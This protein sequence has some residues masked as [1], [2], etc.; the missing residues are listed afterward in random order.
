M[1]LVRRAG[2]PYEAH[3]SVTSVDPPELVQFIRR[4]A[5]VRMDIPRDK[6]G[7]P[8]TMWNLIP[9]KLMPP[10]R[11]VRYCCQYLKECVGKNRINLTGVRW[12][13]SSRRK[14]GW[15]VLNFKGKRAQKMADKLEVP[16]EE[17][18][19]N[20]FGV[21]FD[22]IM[23]DVRDECGIELTED[24]IALGNDNTSMRQMLE[25]CIPRG[26]TV[27]NPIIDWSDEDVW[28]F[29]ETENL[30]VCELY[31]K[32]GGGGD[33]QDS[34]VSGAPCRILEYN[35]KSLHTGL[36]TKKTISEPL[37]VCCRGAES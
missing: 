9:R 11:V 36:S 33:L 16:Y 17:T 20:Q 6:N 21:D 23:E 13:E 35:E 32:T 4:Q 18:Y 5:D 10:T 24:T 28:E 22:Q 25:Y 12:A 29:I 27:L 26:K 2:V 3:Y 19:K 31:H 7:N 15:R 30:P 8:V 14:K 34:D 1:E 37:T